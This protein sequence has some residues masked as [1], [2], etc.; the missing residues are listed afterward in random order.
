MQTICVRPF[1]FPDGS[2]HLPNDESNR[3][4]LKTLV[5]IPDVTQIGDTSED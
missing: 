3:T 4:L 2:M 5:D 1:H